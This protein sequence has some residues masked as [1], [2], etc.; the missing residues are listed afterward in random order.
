VADEP[1]LNRDQL[2]RLIAVIEKVERKRKIMLAGYLVALVVLIGGQVAAFLVF[3]ATPPER[4]IGWIFF[5]PF[6]AVGAVIWLFGRWAS[7]IR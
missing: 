7:G 6:L 1:E 5:L 4:F 2:E 3:A